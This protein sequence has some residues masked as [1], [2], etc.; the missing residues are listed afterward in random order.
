MTAK[1]KLIKNVF[2]YVRELIKQRAQ[3]TLRVKESG[4]YVEL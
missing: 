2:T 1:G 3:D 4:L